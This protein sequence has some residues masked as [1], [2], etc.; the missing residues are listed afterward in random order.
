[1]CNYLYIFL[2]ICAYVCNACTT[3]IANFEQIVLDLQQ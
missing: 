1:M 3:T 2:S